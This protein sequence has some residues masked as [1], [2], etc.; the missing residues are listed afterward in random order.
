[1]TVGPMPDD[2]LQVGLQLDAGPD[3][4]ERE[5]DTLTARLRQEL[6]ELDVESVDPV[7]AGEAPPDTRG[8]DLMVLGGLLVTLSKSPELLKMVIASVQSWVAGRQG[9]SIEVQIEGDTLKVSGV[10]SD[11]Q[12]QLIALFVERHGR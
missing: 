2:V 10:S 4:D 7:R 9:R 12:R 3:T 6:L 1:V 5:I 11:Q 8:I